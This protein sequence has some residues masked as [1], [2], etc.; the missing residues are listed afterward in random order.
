M[1]TTTASATPLILNYWYCAGQAASCSTN[2]GNVMYAGIVTPSLNLLQSFGCDGIDRLTASSEAGSWTRHYGYDQYGNGWVTANSGVPPSASTPQAASN[3]NPQNQLLID[4]AAYDAAGN[5]TAIAGLL[6]THDAENRL[7]TSTLGGVTTAYTYD[8]D[9]RRVMKSSVSGATV[10]VYDA[11][12]QLAAEYGAVTTPP[13]CATCYLTADHLGSTR[14]VTDASGTVQSLTDY[15]PFG[16]EIQSGVGGRPAPYYPS[17]A[18]AVADGVT[19]KFTGK[20]RDVETG[21]DSFGARYFGS[22]PGAF[23]QPDPLLNSGKSSNPQTWNRYSYALNNPLMSV[24]P[25]GLY[26]LVNTCATD[27]KKCNK[28]FA[29]HAKDLKT[30]LTDLQEKVDKNNVNVQFGKTS[31]GSAAQTDLVW[32][33]QTSR[34]GFNVTFDPQHITGGTDDWAVDAA[35]EGTHV[36]DESDPWYNTPATTLSPFQLEYRGHQTSAWAASALGLPSLLYGNGRYQIWNASWGAVDD[37]TL[38][39]FLTDIRD[40]HGNQTHPDTSPNA[41]NPWPN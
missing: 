37:K 38:T 14:M 31:D 26:N 36:A 20:E 18:L 13:P 12:G 28:H 33:Q 17:D 5:Q 16:E 3:Y 39:H 30:G 1:T 27:D 22:A 4:G 8:G 10:Y 41:H 24:D 6:H 19:Q 15:L 9:G 25:N 35:H 40:K 29:Q 2:N 23:H 32:N 11:A 21:L 34:I 7:L